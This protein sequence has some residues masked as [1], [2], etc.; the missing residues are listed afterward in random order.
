VIHKLVEVVAK[1]GNLLL[2]VG[3]TA[4][5]VFPEEVNNTLK[6]IGEWTG[7]HSQAIYGTRSIPNFQKDNIY[8]VEGKKGE[9]YAF[10]LLKEGE[11]LP[12]EISLPWQMENS[13]QNVI[14]LISGERQ[15][16][17]LKNGKMIVRPNKE[18]QKW[19]KVMPAVV[20]RWK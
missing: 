3:P 18:L 20:F 19:S 12:S 13:D 15:S 9:H 6:E 7:V 1:G 4:T 8:F 17:Q 11:Q 10:V 16:I 5:G 2:G 14:E